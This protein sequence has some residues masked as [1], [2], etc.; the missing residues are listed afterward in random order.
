MFVLR[1]YV[2]IICN[3]FLF[4]VN[5]S[6][7]ATPLFTNYSNSFLFTVNV[8]VCATPLFTYYSNSFL[9]IVQT[10]LFVLRQYL[11]IICNSFLFFSCCQFLIY[12]KNIWAEIFS[13]ISPS[14]WYL[15]MCM[16]LFCVIMHDN[17]FFVIFTFCLFKV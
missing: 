4:I 8:S 3:F 7:C 16:Q 9:F 17:L 15:C 10:F 1:Q 14:N 11:P 13:L 12:H 6:V 5:V 2:P